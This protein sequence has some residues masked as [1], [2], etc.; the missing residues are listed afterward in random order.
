ME[1]SNKQAQNMNI[2]GGPEAFQ[3][4]FEQFLYSVGNQYVDTA[5][6]LVY[7]NQTG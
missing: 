7:N 6:C 5:E 3:I 4:Y 2:S 1:L